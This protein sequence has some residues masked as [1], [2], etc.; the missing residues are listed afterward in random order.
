MRDG[1]WKY[2]LAPKPELYD[3]EAD[4]GEQH[5]LEN[6]QQGRARAMRSG[7]DTYLQQE[8]TSIK[9]PSE[10]SG[11]SADRL[12][13]LGALGYVNPGGSSRSANPPAPTRKTSSMNTRR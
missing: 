7:L 6:Q 13:R 5:N 11:L 8:R 3:L 4:P 1:R 9:K 2:I 10:A 12:E